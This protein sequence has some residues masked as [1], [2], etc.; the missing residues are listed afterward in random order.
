MY[1][2]SVTL[3]SLVALAAIVLGT[4]GIWLVHSEIRSKK[5]RWKL[6]AWAAIASL[7]MILLCIGQHIFPDRGWL[8]LVST[9]LASCLYCFIFWKTFPGFYN[10]TP[11]N[12]SPKAR[13]EVPAKTISFG[14]VKYW[15]EAESHES[16][17]SP[18]HRR[19]L[20]T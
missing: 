15:L 1:V 18:R 10:D 14:S 6:Y 17:G 9:I 5:G 3:L 8:N 13:Q 12:N 7:V 11:A 2:T 19:N 16:R 4:I 20:T